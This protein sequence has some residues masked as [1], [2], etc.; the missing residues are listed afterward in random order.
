MLLQIQNNI[1]M[2]LLIENLIRVYNKSFEQYNIWISKKKYEVVGMAQ[3]KDEQILTNPYDID[4]SFD[5]LFVL[6]NLILSK[7]QA[8]THLWPSKPDFLKH[9]TSKYI[10]LIKYY[11][12]GDEKAR[13]YLLDM[14]YDVEKSI[15]SNYDTLDKR[16]EKRKFFCDFNEFEKNGLL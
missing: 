4:I 16:N 5:E 1:T 12:Y 14:G 15:Y 3:I 2:D 8:S 7:D 11:Y 13:S 6:I 9:T 10:S